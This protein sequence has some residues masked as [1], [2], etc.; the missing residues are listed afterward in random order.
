ML[1]AIIRVQFA[2]WWGWKRSS[3]EKA[4]ARLLRRLAFR[5]YHLA[6]EIGEW[7]RETFTRTAWV[8]AGDVDDWNFPV[9]VTAAQAHCDLCGECGRPLDRAST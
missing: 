3:F 6:G 5:A 1:R 2:S 4:R 9:P 8:E 7:A